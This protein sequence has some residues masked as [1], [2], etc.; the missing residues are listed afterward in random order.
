M[1]PKPLVRIASS[2]TAA[3]GSAAVRR[4]GV[5]AGRAAPDPGRC[6]ARQPAPPASCPACTSTA[7]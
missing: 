7:S 2:L 5:G 6:A 3:A 1:Q 4:R